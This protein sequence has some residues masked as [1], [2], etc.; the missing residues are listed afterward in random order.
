VTPTPAYLYYLFAVAMLAVAA[1]SLALL[2]VSV[3]YRR[4]SGWDVDI[5]HLAMGLS[6]AGMFIT[7]WAF[8]PNAL[9]QLIFLLLTV[10]FVARSIQAMQ[11]FGLHLSHYLIH[12][13][14]SFAML[15]MYWFPAQSAQGS[16]MSMSMGMASG[17]ARIQ[18]GLSFLLAVILLSS[19]IFTLASPNKGASHHGTHHRALALS[20]A[21]GGTVDTR[22]EPAALTGA[23]GYV[24]TPWLEDASHVVMCVGMGF[25]LILMI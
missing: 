3:A 9:W 17:G 21:A 19:A 10:W 23:A 12:A 13:T 14:M 20:A 24:A 1:Y 15:L 18:P 2:V 8:G 16:S 5:A 22:P 7:G 11:L 25:M 6:M 4:P